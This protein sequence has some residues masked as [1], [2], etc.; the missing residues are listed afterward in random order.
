MRPPEEIGEERELKGLVLVLV[1]G[2]VAVADV[3]DVI[4]DSSRDEGVETRWTR[5]R[6]SLSS[7]SVHW[8]NASR[9][10][11]IVPVI[12]KPKSVSHTHKQT[13]KQYRIVQYEGIQFLPEKIVGS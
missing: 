3:E 12:Q 10:D 1:V 6:A 2:S 8:L 4:V 11:R 5:W 13:M 7:A 9:L